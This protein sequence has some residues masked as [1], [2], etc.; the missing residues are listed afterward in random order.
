MFLEQNSVMPVVNTFEKLMVH[1]NVPINLQ[2][3]H[4]QECLANWAVHCNIPQNAINKLLSILKFK[5]QLN[6]LPKD[7]RTLLHSGSKKVLNLREVDPNGIYFHF[8]LRE[9]ILR[10][11]SIIVSPNNVIKIAIGIDGLPLTKSSSAQ[12][13][14]ILAYILPHRNHV[15]PVGIFYGSTKPKNSND[16]LK[17]FISEILELTHT[18]IKINNETK[19]VV[20]EVICCDAPAKSYVLGVKGHAGFHSCTRCTHEGEYLKHRICFPYTE[21]GNE[22]RNHEDYISMKNEEH[23]VTGISCLALIPNIDIVSLFSMDYMHLVCLG[24]MRKLI[25]LWL[26]KG[27]TDIRLPSWKIKEITTSLLQIKKCMTNDFP[28]KPRG[29]EEVA[30]WKATEF[31]QFLL[32]SG[33]VILKNI[34]SKD[35]YQHFLTLSISM[36]IMLSLDHGIYLNYANQLLHYFVEH[37]QELY[38]SHF[39]SHNVHG[40]LHLADDYIKHG[41]LD[42]CS[43]FPFE[44]YMKYLKGMLRK[45]EKP[46]QQIV[47]RYDEQIKCEHLKPDQ[48]KNNTLFCTKEPNCFCLT[49]DGYV[50]K[51]TDIIGGTIVGHYFTNKTDLFV[52]PLKSSLLNIFIVDNLSDGTKQWNKDFVNK[53]LIVFN[54]ENKLIAM[55]IIHNL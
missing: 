22:Q 30:R 25:N 38:G 21:N 20:I 43:A 33:P 49:Y 5:A 6:F 4:V 50:V 45:Q 26:N 46:L 14:P 2:Q 35:C 3:Q 1:D 8:G 39:I 47:K 34:L 23:H 51:I 7:C 16:F 18:G 54:F 32:Y 15:F 40:L 11:S 28:R 48:L 29:I 10:Y 24:V 27:S 52:T 19:V 17:D 37:F 31:R 44:N 9:G 41:P 55:P 36:R 42:N 53:K 13:W 12:F